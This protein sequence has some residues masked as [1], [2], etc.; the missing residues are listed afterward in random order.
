VNFADLGFVRVAAVVPPVRLADPAAN[1]AAIA[2]GARRASE[3]G[4]AVAVFPELAVSGYSCEDLFL[5]EGLLSETRAAL[6][7]LAAATR[8]LA[9]AVVAG[10]PYRTPDGRLFNVGFVLHRGRVRGAI[11]KTH[12][13]NYGEFYERRWFVPGGD[14]DL[15]VSDPLLGEFRLATRQLFQAGPLAFAVEI[16]E[17]LWA[18][19]P[20]SCAHALAGA[21]LLLGLNAS[22]EIVAKADYRRD[23]VRQQSARL[24]AAYVYVSTGPGESTKDLV[25]GGHALVAENG[26]LLAEGRRFALEGGFVTADVDLERLAHARARNITFG[27]SEFSREA[28]S[29]DLLGPPPDLPDLERGYSRTPFVPDEP[30]T[31]SER[32]REILSIQATGLARRLQS[33]RSEAAVIGVSGGL[34][35]TLALLVGVE[36]L[37]LLHQPASRVLA[38]SMPG[39]GTTEATRGSAADLAARLGVAF[40]EIPIGKAVEQHFRD[41]GH[42]PRVHD[43]VFENSQA[44]ERTQILFD[45]ANKH[46]GIVVGTGDLSELA[47]GW[48]TYNADHMANYAVNVSVPKTLVKHLVGWY[49]EHVAEAATRSVL[50]KILATTISP[51]LL[52]PAADGGI[53][54]ST[55]EIIGPYVLHDFFLFHHLRNGFRPRK[56][57]AL[58][59]LAFRGQFPP[60]EVKKWLRVF[61]ERFYRQQFKRSCLPPG[62]KVGSVSLSP[63]GDLRMPDEVDPAPLLREVDEL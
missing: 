57:Y 47:L 31:V 17:D 58:A 52:P 19:V 26:A 15:R 18:P 3:R 35:S 22:N 56:L 12:L 54:Q 24:N 4:A 44:R 48:C 39:F 10:A 14:V 53:S 2:E 61:V 21:S 46:R 23:L 13:P 50:E 40:R 27:A 32:A 38:V 8:D 63:R 36:A 33:S 29:V 51:E 49:A 42:D 28:Y 62:P 59:G 37:R 1:A 7:T 11:P 5:S 9:T 16:C 20:P 25:F 34:D 30:A 6:R 45:L 41:I 60:T 43:V 55:E